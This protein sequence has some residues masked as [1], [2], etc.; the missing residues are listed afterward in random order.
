MIQSDIGINAELQDVVNEV[1]IILHSLP[2]HYAYTVCTCIDVT[3][4]SLCITST[5]LS[6]TKT[7]ILLNKTFAKHCMHIV[8]LKSGEVFI[9]WKNACP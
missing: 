3:S 5:L 2:I 9:T 6:F 8:E 7:P 1:I 4:I